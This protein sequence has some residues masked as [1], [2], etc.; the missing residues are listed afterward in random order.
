MYNLYFIDS[1]AIINGIVAR[2]A[3][4]LNAS[5]Y[6]VVLFDKSAKALPIAT[7]IHVGVAVNADCADIIQANNNEFLIC[8]RFKYVSGEAVIIRQKQ[9]GKYSITVYDNGEKNLLIESDNYFFNTFIKDDDLNFSLLSAVGTL[10]CVRGDKLLILLDEKLDMIYMTQNAEYS[11]GDNGFETTTYTNGIIERT[12]TEKYD[13]NGELL[14]RSVEYSSGAE[15]N[16]ELYAYAFMEAILCGD[17]VF[18]R[19]MLADDLRESI[20]DIAM[21]IGEPI[22]MIIDEDL[23]YMHNK[24]LIRYID[25]CK[26]YEITA[27]SDKI[28]N[29]YEI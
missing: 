13:Y 14:S 26:L 23:P 6:D 12:I 9:L 2:Q 4:N 18:A 20:E 19:E 22:E 3:L 7:R 24:V 10:V 28:T 16:K 21:F 15:Y 27:E 5:E 1:Y 29:I 17:Y 8:P 25:S 11:L